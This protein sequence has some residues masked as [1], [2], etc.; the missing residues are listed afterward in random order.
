MA[1]HQ[2]RVGVYRLPPLPRAVGTHSCLNRV[3][4]RYSSI[5]T[6]DID[7]FMFHQ[8]NLRVTDVSTSTINGVTKQRSLLQMWVES[9][10]TEFNSLVNWPMITKSHD[11][12]ATIFKNR[13]TKDQCTRN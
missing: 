6:V 1:C 8:A 3:I 11:Q 7:P 2:K 5:V 10:V 13:M 9:I 12:L 4:P